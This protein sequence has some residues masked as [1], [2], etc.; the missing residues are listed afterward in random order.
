MS[1]HTYKIREVPHFVGLFHSGVISLE[2]DKESPW[3]PR[4]VWFYH[5]SFL[6]C[7]ETSWSAEMQASLCKALL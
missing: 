6:I 2:D 1:I 7:E 3:E 5:T 4:A